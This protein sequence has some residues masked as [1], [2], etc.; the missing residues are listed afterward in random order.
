MA[1]LAE[2]TSLLSTTVKA[3]RLSASKVTKLAD[4]A[5][6]LAP[7]AQQLITT[8]YKLNSSLPPASQARVS[9]LYV[10]DAIVR[11]CKGRPK[12]GAEGLER[13]RAKML[14]KMEGVAE[15]WVKGMTADGKGG[16]W[17]EG[18][19]KTRK[20]IDIWQKHGTFNQSCLDDLRIRL[21]TSTS[22]SK[23]EEN[24]TGSRGSR[25]KESA[26]S[27]SRSFHKRSTTPSTSPPSWLKARFAQAP[28]RRSASSSSRAPKHSRRTSGYDISNEL[29]EIKEQGNGTSEQDGD[30][31]EGEQ[32][33]PG[34]LPPEIAKMLG[35]A[36]ADSTT[37]TPQSTRSTPAT[38]VPPSSNSL[39]PPL[40][41]DPKQLAALAGIT[42]GLPISQPST[43]DQVHGNGSE[44]GYKHRS[45]PQKP[46][47]P[48]S[49]FSPSGSSAGRENRWDEQRDIGR[50]G[51]GDRSRDDYRRPSND[52]RTMAAPMS[53][54]HSHNDSG[55]RARSRSPE[56]RQRFGNG[57]RRARF[58]D[59][60]SSGRVRDEPFVPTGNVSG[61]AVRMTPPSHTSS[62]PPPPP[63][64]NP[65]PPFPTPAAQ[66][67]PEPTRL[68]L[69]D[70]PLHTFDPSDPAAWVA[71][72]QAWTNSMGR[73]PGGAELMGWLAMYSQLQ[74]GMQA[75]Q[76]PGG[77]GPEQNMPPGMN[78]VSQPQMQEV[79]GMGQWGAQTQ[80]TSSGQTGWQQGNG[81]QQGSM[82]GMRY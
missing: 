71:L 55:A 18:K 62:L 51:R 50:L 72:G 6:S 52:G 31:R 44:D 22:T 21:D 13:A 47:M 77:A 64:V 74:A 66:P 57:E 69:E 81:G 82:N 5:Q 45:S 39:P 49:S 14:H 19:E 76:V 9:S 7:D 29:D 10:F 60:E 40:G 56:K 68:T 4:L 23:R 1:D 15:S 37:A 2:F 17:T 61:I 12:E 27:A 46:K 25:D 8:F 58:A 59:D 26:T 48:R 54:S 67:T 28:H 53:R 80:Y 42:S 41:I 63:N 38:D 35:I 79:Q 24:G 20:I 65:Q 11:A 34:E 33:K 78:G 32:S 70:F 30:R 43:D 75:G 36:P 16:V 73:E 3:P